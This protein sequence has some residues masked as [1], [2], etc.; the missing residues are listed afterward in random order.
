MIT[1]QIVKLITYNATQYLTCILNPFGYFFFIV[2][3]NIREF[4]DD[5]VQ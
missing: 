4:A 5:I 3:I 2:C 1:I